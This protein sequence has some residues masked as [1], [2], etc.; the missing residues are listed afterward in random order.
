MTDTRDA[1]EETHTGAMSRGACENCVLERF[2][3]QA[4]AGAGG[5]SLWGPP[6]G[7]CHQVPCPGSHFVDPSCYEL[8]QTH[9]GARVQGWRV[10]GV[11]GGGNSRD[12][13]SMSAT[14]TL[15]SGQSTCSLLG[16]AWG[17]WARLQGLGVHLS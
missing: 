13:S 1:V 17:G 15:F 9:K 6:R 8:A 7:I 14:L 16:I 12:Q 5:I 3:F 10:V 4:T 11:G 2:W